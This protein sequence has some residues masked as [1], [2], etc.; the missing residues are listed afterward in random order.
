MGKYLVTG[1]AGFIG[2]AV[3]ARLLEQGASVTTIDD[4]STGFRENIPSGVDCIEGDCGQAGTISQLG[5]TSF[6]GIVHI[7][8][9]SSGEISFE[10][11][12]KDL[13]SN[14]IS[15]LLLLRY[16]LETGCRKFVYA[17]SMS[18]YGL[19]ETAQVSESHSCVPLSFYGANKLLSEHYLRLYAAKG[20]GARA[21]RLFN[22]YGPGQ[23]FDNLKQGMVSIFLAQALRDGSIFVRGPGERYR[24]FVYIDDVVEAFLQALKLDD[25]DFRALNICSGKRT[26]VDELL[27]MINQGLPHEVPIEFGEKTEGDVP[28]IVGDGK[29]ARELLAWESR[30]SIAEGLQ[31]MIA[32]SR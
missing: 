18:V 3:C 13:R 5:R 10:N 1:G 15:T 32:A 11:P 30:V 28:G 21:L 12:E 8:G 29:M 24:D 27:S 22:V 7:A 9:Q 16:A 14:S 23:N 25:I 20:V 26:S 4:F 19:P 17:S 31:R 6:D 2:A